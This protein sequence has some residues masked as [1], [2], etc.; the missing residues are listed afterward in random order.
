MLNLRRFLVLL[1]VA[2][3]FAWPL[4]A[5]VMA[6]GD[7]T[8]PPAAADPD[9]TAGRAA[10]EKKD[11]PAAAALFTKVLAKNEANADA[12]NWL[13][14]ARRNMGDLP[15]ALKSYARALDID[16]RH[17][18]AHEYVGEAYLLMGD[19]PKAEQHLAR[20]NSICWFGC[21]EYNDL[22]AKIAEFKAKKTS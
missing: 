8:P 22:K 15:G 3:A 16:P 13:G 17:R 7:T 10:I 12:H 21:E 2:A 4:P 14:Y 20:L 5:P 9:F 11:W 19:L 6:A 1:G 18:G